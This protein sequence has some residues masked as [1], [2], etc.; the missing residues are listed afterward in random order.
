M[1]GELLPTWLYQFDLADA[2]ATVLE[3]D[4]VGAAVGVIER[5]AGKETSLGKFP[6]T[7][8]ELERLP[9]ASDRPVVLRLPRSASLEKVVT[10]PLAAQGGLEQVLAFEMDRETPFSADE[11]YWNHRVVAVNR[12][13]G[14]LS[15]RLQL[16][17]KTRLASL[18]STLAQAGIV[19]QW[20]EIADED[21]ERQCLP[22]GDSHIRA[23]QRSRRLVVLAAGCC[24]LLAF[25][26]LALPLAR[27]AAELATLNSKIE[28]GR[29]IASQ[30][31]TL[32]KEIDRLTRN[33]ELVH[34]QRTKAGRPLEQLAAVTR[35]LPDDTYLTELELRQRKLTI[36]GRSTAAA[37]LI[38]AL[39]ADPKFRNPT[40]AAPVT[41]LEA[42]H[43]EVFSIVADAEGGP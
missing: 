29:A 20:A 38:A 14:R 28:A 42:L 2:N 39:A 4:P 40:F 36:G 31:E 18:L 11:L 21:G 33:A 37:Q 10:L 7:V 43:V 8:A 1:L 26:A 19:P 16:L 25:A 6:L 15:V 35:L 13:L 34:S 23:R 5:R 17:P 41:R 24:A 22:L 32:R 3:A 12:Q 27:Q 30:A 9:R